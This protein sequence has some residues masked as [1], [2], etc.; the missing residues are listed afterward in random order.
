VLSTAIGRGGGPGDPDRRGGLRRVAIDFAPGLGQG[1]GTQPPEVSL[2]CR[3]GDCTPPVLQ[4]NPGTGGWRVTF[5]AASGDGTELRCLLT[6]S[7]RPVSETWLY[8]LDKT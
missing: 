4:P 3:N 5:D 7:G 6:Q 2:E 8:R 1:P